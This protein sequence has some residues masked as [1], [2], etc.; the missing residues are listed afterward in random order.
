MWVVEQAGP[1]MSEREPSTQAVKRLKKQ[2]KTFSGLVNT[3]N[4]T[5]LLVQ[6]VCLEYTRYYSAVAQELEQP[7]AELVQP[8]RKQVQE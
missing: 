1:N 6:Q 3:L 8:E 4:H 2:K 7:E 5:Q